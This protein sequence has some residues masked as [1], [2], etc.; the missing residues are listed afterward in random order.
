MRNIRTAQMRELHIHRQF[1]NFL[2]QKRRNL[3]GCININCISFRVIV[4]NIGMEMRVSGFPIIIK[5][6]DFLG[7]SCCFCL[8]DHPTIL[9][10]HW[11]N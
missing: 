7:K 9:E 3:E 8:D 10:I 5:I 2:F 1:S 4:F 6:D 11:E